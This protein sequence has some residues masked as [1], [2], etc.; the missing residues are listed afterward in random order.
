MTLFK[1]KNPVPTAVEAPQSNVY[2][3][4]ITHTNE[5]YFEHAYIIVDVPHMA[6]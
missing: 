5:S 3:I 4:A 2:L 1:R 6:L